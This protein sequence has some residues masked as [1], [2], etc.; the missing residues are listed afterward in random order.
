MT[1][2]H[3]FRQILGWAAVGAC[4]TLPLSPAAA[5]AQ[6]TDYSL[7]IQEHLF[8]N[9]LRL[10]VVERPA[11]PRV[12]AKIFTDFGAIIE[13]PGELGAAHFLE[14]LM[15]KGTHT[16]G[17]LDWRQEAPL[18][19]AIMDAEAALVEEWNRARNTV[20]QRG[21]FHDFKHAESTPTMDSLQAVIDSLSEQVSELRD[22]GAMMRWYQA[23]GGT[24]LTATTEQ[25]YMKF[26]I[27]LPRERIDLFLRVEAD[28]MRNTVFREFDEERMI[29][30]EQRLGDLNRPTTPFYEA[31]TAVV[32][33]VHPVFYPEGY[34]TD[35][36]EY[37]RGFEWRLYREY[38]V[39]N[40]TTLVFV[41]GVTLDEMI[42]RVERWF[43]GMARAP[44]PTR[45]KGV[46][47]IPRGERRLVWR[48]DDLA[49]RVDVRHLIPGVGHPDRPLVDVLGEVL[50]MEVDAQLRL[51]G[52]SAT[53]DVNTRVVHE[54][55]FGV[56]GS[57]NVEVVTG[58][59]R[60]VPA[61]ERA[62]VRALNRVAAGVIPSER[63]ALAKKKLR[64]EWFRTAANTDALAFQIGH[65]QTMDRWQTLEPFLQARDEATVVD[66]QRV[67][68][69]YLVL[70]NRTTATSVGAGS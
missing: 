41:G 46:E 64:T 7:G 2:T 51:G 27:N 37:T 8:D 40:N 60:T 11:D 68:S 23:Y 14:H 16:L 9:G 34:P 22:H 66:L 39:P 30:V 29:L 31:V 1:K 20:R 4:A 18:D 33:A 10:L 61:A 32:G 48:S 65:F 6:T 25:E 38:F 56:P 35:F 3:R 15:F 36:Y 67:A 13:L 24:G 45:S 58:N 12:A 49:A 21:V 17:T 26:D 63:L 47:P 5:G 28:R 19:Q 44:E 62:V 59:E 54:S 50:R 52:V 69:K 57:L 55:R 43:G 53:T 70:D 42:P